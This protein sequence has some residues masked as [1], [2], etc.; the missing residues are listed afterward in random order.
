VDSGTY[1]VGGAVVSSASGATDSDGVGVGFFL[2]VLALFFGSAGCV[3]VVAGVRVF[4]G[5]GLSV[6]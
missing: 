2:G 3:V 1:S 4:G 6:S 5:M